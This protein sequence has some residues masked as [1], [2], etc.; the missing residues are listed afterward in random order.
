MYENY[1]PEL[2]KYEEEYQEK[3]IEGDPLIKKFYAY[4]MAHIDIEDTPL[5]IEQIMNVFDLIER[6]RSDYSTEDDSFELFSKINSAFAFAKEDGVP[7]DTLFDIIDFIKRGIVIAHEQLKDIRK[8][9][10][11]KNKYIVPPQNYL[12]N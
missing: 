12:W 11:R 10:P 9:E 5:S 3:I 8:K 7:E 6:G 4:V 2:E 1:D